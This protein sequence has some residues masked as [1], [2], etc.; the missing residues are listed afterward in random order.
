MIQLPLAG[1]QYALN[2]F[3][4][5]FTFAVVFRLPACCMCLL[6]SL[7]CVVDSTSLEHPSATHAVVVNPGSRHA[8]EFLGPEMANLQKLLA[9]MTTGEIVNFTACS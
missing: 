6:F 3:F 2:F 7:Q 8:L 1:L 5:S 9:A 4:S